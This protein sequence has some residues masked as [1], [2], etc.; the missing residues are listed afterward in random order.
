MVMGKHTDQKVATEEEFF[1][2]EQVLNETADE[3]ANCLKLLKKHLSDY[4][5]RNDNQSRN[6]A[7]SFMRTDMRNA[8]DTASDLKYVAHE[9]NRNQKPSKTEI[10]S[11]RNMMDSTA[12]AIE[13]L[14][15]TARNY[16]RENK[17]RMGVKGRVDAAVG[18]RNNKGMGDNRGLHGTGEMH[19]AREDDRGYF[20]KN[21]NERREDRG[22]VGMNE[23]GADRGFV[24]KIENEHGEDR[25]FVGKNERGEDRGL[26]GKNNN[27]RGEDGGF[28]GNTS[29]SCGGVLDKNREEGNAHGGM[30]GGVRNEGH[31]SGA[32]GGNKDDN[33]GVMGSSETVETLVRKILR[34][35]FSLS[36]LDHQIKAAEKSLSPSLMERAK[37]KMHDVKEKIKGDKSEPVHEGHGYPHEGHHHQQTAMP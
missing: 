24:G 16:D 12:R 30:L 23:S 11:A 7:A 20:G 18:G 35:H 33:G 5:S 8:K 13:T 36:A 21:E 10:A 3:T 14:K 31:H 1:K 4:D 2:L 19:N 9:I 29:A 32:L 25:G 27:E 37:E 15:T 6:T 26:F 17:Q 34:D 22:F 28:L